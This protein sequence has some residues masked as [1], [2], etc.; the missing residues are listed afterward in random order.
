M[1][2]IRRRASQIPAQLICAGLLLVMAI[3]LLSVIARKSI[4][5][6]ETLVIPS[7]Y[8]YLASRKFYIEPDHPPLSKLLAGLPLIFLPLKT[9]ELADLIGEP[10]RDQTIFAANR[11]WTTN[12]QHFE[13][14]FF[15]ARV[16][17]VIL[18]LLLGALIFSF[19]RQLFNVRAGVLAVALFTFEPTI[20]AHGRILKDIHVAFVY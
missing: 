19:A 9:P 3:N 10:S 5:I 18:T 15:W 20:L 16:P 17:M 14:V 4:T 6:D 7:G 2:G 8:Y 1:G 11:F 13:S 12:R